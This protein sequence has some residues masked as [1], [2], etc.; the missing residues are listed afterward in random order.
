MLLR[1]QT[2]ALK[3]GPSVPRPSKKRASIYYRSGRVGEIEKHVSAMYE[4]VTVCSPQMQGHRMAAAMAYETECY[5]FPYRHPQIAATYARLVAEIHDSERLAAIAFLVGLCEGMANAK[6]DP[7]AVSRRASAE[8]WHVFE[9]SIDDFISHKAVN[10]D[11]GT[12]EPMD[13]GLMQET[14]AE[15]ESPLARAEAFLQAL[16]PLAENV[17]LQLKRLQR[18]IPQM[19]GPLLIARHLAQSCMPPRVSATSA[20]SAA[21][22][23]FHVTLN[24]E[25]RREFPAIDFLSAAWHRE[26]RSAVQ[27]HHVGQNLGLMCWAIVEM[28]VITT[29]A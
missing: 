20:E 22:E 17:F 12:F 8:D 28:G 27:F 11:D 14:L 5:Q 29:L 19:T 18:W 25:H 2:K 4:F 23:A 9:Q 26:L 15:F 6:V 21:V 13:I 16:R 1:G 7:V 24:T 10:L 3:S